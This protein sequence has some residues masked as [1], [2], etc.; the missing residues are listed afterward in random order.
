MGKPAQRVGLVWCY[1]IRYNWNIINDSDIRIKENIVNI[2]NPLN[3]IKQIRGVRYNLKEEY[4]KDIPEAQKEQYMQPDFGFIAQELEK[5][6][7]EMVVEDSLGYLSV[8]YIR[9]IPVLVEAIK[10]QQNIIEELQ[11]EILKRGKSNEEPTINNDEL[12]QEINALKETMIKCCEINQQRTIEIDEVN[13]I[14]PLL[15]NPTIIPTEEMKVYQN[16][17][18]PFNTN[19]IIQCYIPQS[20]KKVELCI[21]DMRGVQVKCI[22]ISER[23]M[24][25]VQIQAGQLSAGVYTYLLIGDGKTSDAKQMILTN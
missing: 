24:V 6:F 10:E 17:P 14:K 1:G 25:N 3:K 2:E 12:K 11:N 8:K 16:I 21:Y 20:I 22:K 7:P 18:N 9:M 5:V 23:E 15:T 4:L 13:D 19:T